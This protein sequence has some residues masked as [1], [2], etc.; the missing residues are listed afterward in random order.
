MFFYGYF[1]AHAMDFAKKEGIARGLQ[2]CLIHHYANENKI[3][4]GFYDMTSMIL[5]L[6]SRNNLPGV[7]VGIEGGSY[8]DIENSIIPKLN[9]P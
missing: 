9:Y 8:K 6:C 3:T 5:C 7:L 1:L 4:P 2:F